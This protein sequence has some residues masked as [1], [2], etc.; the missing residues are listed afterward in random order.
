M[1][2][3]IAVRLFAGA[4]VIAIAALVALS[5]F[6]VAENRGR[7]RALGA[8]LFHEDARTALWQMEMRVA[9]MLT[10]ATYFEEPGQGNPAGWLACGIDP[11]SNDVQP[12]KAQPVAVAL[13]AQVAADE[14]L[15]SAQAYALAEPGGRG[16][17]AL[18]A[19]PESWTGAIEQRGEPRSREDFQLR[20]T[21][22]MNS[23]QQLRVLPS[24]GLL[25]GPLAT[26]WSE[27]ESGDLSLFLSR[28]VDGAGGSTGTRYETFFMPWDQLEGTLL[29][30]VESLFPKAKLRPIREEPDPWE[31]PASVGM[32]LASIPV[33]FD[34]SPPA[35]TPKASLM[36]W[37][38]LISAWAGLGLALVCGFVGL[39]ASLAY[40]DKH[41]RFT[42]AVTHELRTPLTTFRMYSEM[43]RS[44]MVPPGAE[45]E[46]LRTLESESC[47]LVGLVENV[48]SYARLEEGGELPPRERMT[49]SGLL[50]SLVP[51]VNRCAEPVAIE[52]EDKAGSVEL[53]T[54]PSAVGQVLTNLV[55][56]ATKYGA[57]V[58]GSAHTIRVVLH[59][60]AA[61]VHLD[62]IDGGPGI[63]SEMR[64]R[65]FAPF[66]RAGRDSSDA[67]PGV[68]LGLALSRRLAAQLGGR[69]D[70]IGAE[71]G[72]TFRLSLPRVLEGQ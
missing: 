21:S 59:A 48:L 60:D 68:G 65:M 36:H 45:E 6:V 19:A 20:Q 57:P 29:G 3:S 12:A 46:Y 33:G 18:Q 51:G 25:V 14:A 55:E 63:G 72:A 31:Q 28:R 42:H 62:V 70:W 27:D 69:L 53:T 49:A 1:N 52:F 22:N 43:L 56:N 40:G 5:I 34:V 7:E 11:A 24:K 35:L 64:A 9:G 15:E 2:R 61:S 16:G 4:S 32:R 23:L 41:R 47:R 44:G 8:A 17:P 58:D 37:W 71:K 30:E 67:A 54:D 26:F 39:R 13:C 66:D 50:E 10:A 38:P